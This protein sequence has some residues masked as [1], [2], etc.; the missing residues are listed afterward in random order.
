[1]FYRFEYKLNQLSKETEKVVDDALNTACNEADCIC[2]LQYLRYFTD[3]PPLE[4]YF[5]R[6]TDKIFEF[7]M[8]DMKRLTKMYSKNKYLTCAYTPKYS[9]VSLMVTINF[10][11]I[12]MIKNVIRKS[13]KITYYDYKYHSIWYR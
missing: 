12:T 9:G 13:F 8:K 4:A 1:M 5:R 3:W 11:H 7:V 6:K 10:K 2:V